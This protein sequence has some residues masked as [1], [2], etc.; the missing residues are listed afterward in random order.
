MQPHHA[1]M[2]ANN[3]ILNSVL[4]HVCYLIFGEGI[5]VIRIPSLL[6]FVIY[7]GYGFRFYK[8][9]KNPFAKFILIVFLFCTQYIIEFFGLSR[10]YAMSFAFLLGVIYH[11]KS[12]LKN[13]S[14]NHFYAGVIMN[15]LMILSNLSLITWS[16]AFFIIHL[17][18]I[19]SNHKN[20]IAIIP[21][22]AA[23]IVYITTF[24]YLLVYVMALKK[25][26]A[27]YLSGGNSF[28]QVIF[29]GL[30]AELGLA[31]LKYGL[32]FTVPLLCI[33]IILFFIHLRKMGKFEYLLF[34]L[35]IC[36]NLGFIFAN[37]LMNINYP[38]NRTGIQ[39]YFILILGIVFFV[40]KTSS[41]I[42]NYMSLVPAIYLMVFFILNLQFTYVYH[43]KKESIPHGFVNV[44][45]ELNKN[46][47]VPLTVSAHPHELNG[48]DYY[49]YLYKG[50]MN[51]VNLENYPNFES[52]LVV[53]SNRYHG[54][55]P[56]NFDTIASYLPTQHFLI[57]N[58]NNSNTY[59]EIKIE[60]INC[61]VEYTSIYTIH[62]D[63]LDTTC[64]NIG[65]S[66][67]LE[68]KNSLKKSF[69][70]FQTDLSRTNDKLDLMH[71]PLSKDENDI[72]HLSITIKP[73]PGD[74]LIKVFVW[75]PSNSK[76]YLKNITLYLEDKYI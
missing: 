12:S 15:T 24:I 52:D 74:K 53:L 26:G 42:L 60:D 63:S 72:M 18:I 58:Q 73:Q 44:V 37:R 54:N 4:G 10:G 3:H 41:R 14:L 1:L 61:T 34:A 55:I 65:I 6:S 76:F 64:I 32:F 38:P 39:I 21:V 30:S 62:L 57:K 75:N 28:Y 48:W 29:L 46:R 23:C 31:N 66:F 59:R 45:K 25:T 70:S 17:I 20:K 27:L 33:W 50:G 36:F 51:M 5:W 11:I 47:M 19:L 56:P 43:W 13:S 49:N 16:P 22:I 40:E 7:A 9:L 8:D 67:R 35:M 2:D 68:A 71:V 69:I